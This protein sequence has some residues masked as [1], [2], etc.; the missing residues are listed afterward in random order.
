MHMDRLMTEIE[1]KKLALHCIE[2]YCA[3]VPAKDGE[4]A[5][6]R[7]QLKRS[8]RQELEELVNMDWI[9]HAIR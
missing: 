4:M 7:V 5:R 6:A 8:L 2:M 3:L 1:Q 9:Q